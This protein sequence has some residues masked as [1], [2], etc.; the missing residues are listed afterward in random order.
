V[1][2][3]G[4]YGSANREAM[5]VKVHVGRDN[6]SDRR[7]GRGRLDTFLA[8]EHQQSAVCCWLDGAAGRS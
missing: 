2:F 5:R 6:S 7:C 3:P 8:L 1:L 4:V